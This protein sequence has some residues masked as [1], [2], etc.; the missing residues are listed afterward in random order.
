MVDNNSNDSPSFT[1]FGIEEPLVGSLD[2]I[3]GLYEDETQSADP[4]G[5][6]PIS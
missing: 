2:L 1:N 5:I 6:T 3:Q 4:K